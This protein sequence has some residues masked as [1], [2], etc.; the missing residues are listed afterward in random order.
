[1]APQAFAAW[2]WCNFCRAEAAR[3]GRHPLLLN[4][5][6]TS[7]PL[8]FTPRLSNVIAATS[9]QRTKRR[10]LPSIAQ[11]RETSRANFTHVA[12][13]CDDPSLQPLL[14][15]ILIFSKKQL[16]NMKFAW[17]MR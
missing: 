7:V 5:D 8:G 4:L 10:H 1:M 11:K 15:Q 13:I 16:Q 9:R 14:P 2:Q 6:E 3:L 12:I 17:K